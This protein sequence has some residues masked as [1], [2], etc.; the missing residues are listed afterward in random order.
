M[1]GPLSNV[2]HSVENFDLFGNGI[3]GGK[4]IGDFECFRHS[5]NRVRDTIQYRLKIR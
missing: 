1:T 2:S 5:F 3:L 4:D